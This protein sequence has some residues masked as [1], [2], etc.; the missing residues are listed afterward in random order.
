[1]TYAPMGRQGGKVTAVLRDC[2]VITS[3]IVG[4]D[5]RAQPNRQNLCVATDGKGVNQDVD[6]LP[7]K[8]RE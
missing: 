1:M 4:P 7:G 8:S 3:F 2:L 6:L 5:G